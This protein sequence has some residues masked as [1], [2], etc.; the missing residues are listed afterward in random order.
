[1][2]AANLPDY[3]DYRTRL[4]ATYPL[5]AVPGTAGPPPAT[6]DTPVLRLFAGRAPD[7]QTL[8]EDI[9]G[10][11]AQPPTVAASHPLPAGG[12]DAI[13]TAGRD[14]LD[15]Y[16]QVAGCPAG[17][18]TANEPTWMPERLEYRASIAAPGPDAETILSAA[19]HTAGTLDW[20]QFDLAASSRH[21]AQ[22][23]LTLGATPADLPPTTITTYALPTP[24][25]Y[26]GMPSSRFWEFEDAA[27]NF[28]DM[29]EP[30]EGLLSSLIV[31]YALC[32]G[33]DHYL[34]P[35]P[36]PL[37]S[38]CRV[39]RLVVTTTYGER[40][41]IRPVAELEPSGPFRLFE[42]TLPPPGQP[43]DQPRDPMFVLF[44]AVE[45]GLTSS[46]IESVSYLRDELAEIVWAIERTA[47][48]PAGL[49]TD[50]STSTSPPPAP[51]NTDA[52]VRDYLLRTDVEANWFPYLLADPITR[53]NPSTMT[54]TEMRPV[55]GSAPPR[56]WGDLLLDAPALQQEEVTQAGVQAARIWRYTRW[57]DGSH[58]CWVGRSIRP[59][60]GE[61]SSGLQYDI[62]AATAA[63]PSTQN[64]S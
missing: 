22:P 33:N 46:A 39:S 53:P 60:R 1:M 25:R 42:H 50:R 48:G 56:P 43:G 55:D 9:V 45:Q 2:A 27:I 14:W 37:G 36:L 8:Y 3:A 21:T 4:L 54:L 6:A 11:R 17:V 26:A 15:F 7:A 41:L 34:I 29:N 51:P 47:L 20:Y 12:V 31:D 23:D 19:E 10:L 61:G 35:F 44:P 13:A 58:Y 49:P 32:Y 30:A 62:A 5:P 57:T 28:G 63:T 59:G 16:D 18:T 40:I 24:V 52:Q 38:V 64:P